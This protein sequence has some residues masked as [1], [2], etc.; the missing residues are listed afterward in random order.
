[1][2]LLLDQ[3]LFPLT[4]DLLR[5]QG[6]DTIHVSDIGWARA[7]D[8]KIIELAQTNNQIIIT[9]DSDFHAWVA[10]ASAPSP[11]VVWIRIANLRPLELV[12]LIIS[13]LNE[14]EDVLIKGV[15]ITVRADRKIKLRLLPINLE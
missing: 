5:Q 6:I 10:L 11:S 12:E 2:K 3:G 14:Y 8:I 1:M 13:I 15:L 7:E 9:F 4:A